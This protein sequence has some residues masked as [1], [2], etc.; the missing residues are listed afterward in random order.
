[1]ALIVSPLSELLY[2]IA[3]GP[4]LSS[5]APALVVAGA[6]MPI[7]FIQGTGDRWGT[8][9]DVAHMAAMAPQG[10]VIFPE[11]PHR[12]EGYTWILEHPEVCMDFFRIHL[13]KPTLGE[14]PRASA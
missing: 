4:A 6:R 13:T 3:G 11:T 10:S 12:F 1:L 5:I 2:R 9:T 14:K 7:L 8:Q